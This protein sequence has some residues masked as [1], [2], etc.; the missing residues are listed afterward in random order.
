M[1]L[2]IEILAR[3]DARVFARYHALMI[4]CWKGVGSLADLEL[5]ISHYHEQRRRYPEGFLAMTIL[6]HGTPLQR[7]AEMV[8]YGRASRR[9]FADDIVR[10]GYV[11]PHA[12]FGGTML[13]LMINSVML[14]VPNA[15]MRMYQTLPEVLGYLAGG[16]VALPERAALERE[17]PI[18]LGLRESSV[19]SS[20]RRSD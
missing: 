18:A 12:G 3:S 10:Q 1:A 19:R 11:I 6:E 9:E 8:D 15:H 7:D 5:M 17:L 2:P 4:G 14:L 16:R 13:R 20:V